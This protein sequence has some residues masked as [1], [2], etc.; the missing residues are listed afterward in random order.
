MK[1][2]GTVLEQKH[3]DIWH[4]VSYASRSLSSAEE[5]YCQLEKK[6]CQQYLIVISFMS[7]ITEN[8]LT[9]LTIIHL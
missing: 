9:Y 6:S 1:G 8:N 2:L 5:N 7:L 4:P 3:Y